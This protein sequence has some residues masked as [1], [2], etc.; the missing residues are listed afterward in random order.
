MPFNHVFC[1][2]YRKGTCVVLLLWWELSVV[3]LRALIARFNLQ[4]MELLLPSPHLQY[5]SVALERNSRFQINVSRLVHLG[6]LEEKIRKLGTK[7]SLK[8]Y[9]KTN[10]LHLAQSVRIGFYP[11]FQHHNDTERC[12]GEGVSSSYP[13]DG[14]LHREN[15]PAR[16]EVWCCSCFL[17]PNS[18]HPSSIWAPPVLFKFFC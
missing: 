17:L 12:V 13:A 14:E 9:H 15:G 1:Q 11:S 4:H 16:V 2:C 8:F 18:N 10:T 6:E 3:L 5:S 7:Y